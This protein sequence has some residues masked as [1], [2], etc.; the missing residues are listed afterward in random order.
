MES[1]RLL[2]LFCHTAPHKSV[3]YRYSFNEI[4]RANFTPVHFI[5]QP[6]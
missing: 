1:V 6:L 3:K 5:L 4:M 2:Q